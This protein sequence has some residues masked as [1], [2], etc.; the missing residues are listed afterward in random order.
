MRRSPCVW[1]VGCL[2]GHVALGSSEMTILSSSG[3][4]TKQQEIKHEV[5]IKAMCTFVVW[6]EHWLTSGDFFVRKNV[7]NTCN[8]ESLKVSLN[9]LCYCS[10]IIRQYIKQY[11]LHSSSMLIIGY[12][13]NGKWTSCINFFCWFFLLLR[14]QYVWKVA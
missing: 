13:V 4:N 12:F 2:V 11:F 7:L 10:V 3:Q 9:F 8:M 6:C 14:Y 1:L 5:C